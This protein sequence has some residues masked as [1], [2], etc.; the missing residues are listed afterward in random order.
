M[1]DHYLLN[2]YQCDPEK[3][4][5]EKF[6]KN[7]LHDSAYCAEMTVLQVVTHKFYPQGVTGIALLAESHISIHT[8][9]EE[10]KA[11]V[12]VYTC[13]IKDSKLACDIIRV[14]LDAK[15]FDMEY[16]KR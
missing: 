3:L 12:D 5:D 11:A 8:W 16:I 2:L 13:G 1:G 6:I 14:Q 9:P 7:L 15:Q 10:C 4:D